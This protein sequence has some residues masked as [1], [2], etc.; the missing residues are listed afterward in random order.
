[1]AG[2]KRTIL[3]ALA[4]L[5]VIVVALFVQRRRV[6]QLATYQGI[7]ASAWAVNFYPTFNP[8]SSN[9][10]TFA[11]ETMGT[12]AVPPLRT[13]LKSRKP[14]Y[15]RLFAQQGKFL[16]A[17]ARNY[18]AGKI[19]PDRSVMYRVAAA[20]ALGVVGTNATAAIP[21]LVA[22]LG[23]SNTRWASAQALASIG[24]PAIAAL[25]A[26]TTNQDVN[27]RHAAVYGLGQG[28]TNSWPATQALLDRLHDDREEVRASA[29]YALGRVGPRGVPIVLAAFSSE[30]ESR[31]EAAAKAIKAM[32][33]PP[34]QV[35]RTLLEYA[36]NAS[37]SLR[38]NAL[39]ALQVLRISHPRVIVNYF[40]AT[41]D[42]APGVRAVAA[43]ALVQAGM[44]RTNAALSN[45]VIR[46][47]GRSGD[48][49]RDVEAALNPL[50]TDP[51]VSVRTAAQQT[52]ADLQFPVAN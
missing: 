12:N 21:D 34:R 43:R 28:A 19:K 22:A 20:R 8:S 23:D 6:D 50:L 9:I 24:G 39:E 10:T 51:E 14:W 25:A 36:T 11:F 47:L 52:L 38:Q 29:L 32:N 30:S 26:A 42:V 7:H 49:S 1:M 16:P 3:I 2:L 5:V 37:P 45:A 48:L 18:L 41:K 46:L 13:M 33:S 35:L 40:E 15:A 31:R 44:W 17:G 27:V 4:V